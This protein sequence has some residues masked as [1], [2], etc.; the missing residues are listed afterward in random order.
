V[1]LARTAALAIGNAGRFT[2]DLREHPSAVLLSRTPR[3]GSGAL[4]APFQAAYV[5]LSESRDIG[6]ARRRDKEPPKVRRRF[7]PARPNRSWCGGHVG[8]VGNGLRHRRP[9]SALK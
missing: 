5:S 2:A 4:V 8:P 3:L 1:L 6:N 7:V 9:T